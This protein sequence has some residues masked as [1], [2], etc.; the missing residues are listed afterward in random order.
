[1]PTGLIPFG[2]LW[3]LGGGVGPYTP[4]PP[5]PGVSVIDVITG[6]VIPLDGPLTDVLPFLSP[7]NSRQQLA[8]L[9]LLSLLSWRAAG[10]D[11]PLPAAERNGWWADALDDTE[12]LGS[13]LWLLARG[14]AS[15]DSA[16]RAREYAEEA[17]AWMVTDGACETVTVTTELDAAAGR[18]ALSVVVDAGD[19]KKIAVQFADLWGAING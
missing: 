16:N 12:P 6:A 3:P 7:Q 1:M 15:V 14:R 8:Q 13:R 2:P 19:G 5:A 18:I 10:A 17:L 11:D 4:E 9:V